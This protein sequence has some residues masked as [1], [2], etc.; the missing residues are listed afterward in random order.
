GEEWNAPVLQLA[1]CAQTGGP[2][3]VAFLMGPAAATHR[4][5][6][7]V[8][9]LVNAGASDVVIVPLLV[10]SHSGHYEQIRYLAGQTDTLDETMMHHLHMGGLERPQTSARLSVARALDDAAELGEVLAARAA[11]LTTSP[12]TQALYLVGHG[13]NSA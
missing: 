13:P 9:K 5:Q 4:F 8:G 6:D 10:S 11:K 2:V 7:Q 12:S 1:Q 3:E